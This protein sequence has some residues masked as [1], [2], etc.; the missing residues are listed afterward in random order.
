MQNVEKWPNLFLKHVW[1]F[2]NIYERIKLCL[3]MHWPIL[4]I[5][6]QGITLMYSK[7]AAQ[8][9]KNKLVWNIIDKKK[10]TG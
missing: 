1:P 8:N 4:K 3:Q 2:F 7:I 6:Q 10:L 5:F 9:T